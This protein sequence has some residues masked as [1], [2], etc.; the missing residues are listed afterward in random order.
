VSFEISM[1][2]VTQK[3]KAP[4]IGLVAVGIV[5]ALSGIL[6]ILATLSN[7]MRASKIQFGSD[8][9]RLGYLV[10]MVVF[11]LSSLTAIVLSPVIIYG[12]SQMLKVRRY[13]LARLA[14]ILAI[15]PFVSCC[16]LLGIPVGV[17]AL[18]VLKQPDVKAAFNVTRSPA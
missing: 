7:L 3:L 12:A 6:I 16:F 9:E 17:W 18:S 8:A 5:N 15:I 10:S 2:E 1:S 11:V 14:A 4:A 13:G